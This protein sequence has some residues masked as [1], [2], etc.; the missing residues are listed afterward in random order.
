MR[1]ARRRGG[2]LRRLEL[3][4]V[5]LTVAPAV[6]IVTLLIVAPRSSSDVLIT[7]GYDGCALLV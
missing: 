4:D 1:P 2:R 6:P 5:E 7:I 3:P